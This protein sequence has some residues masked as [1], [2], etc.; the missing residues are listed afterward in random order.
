MFATNRSKTIIALTANFLLTLPFIYFLIW[1]E[2]ADTRFINNLYPLL[3]L[4]IASIIIVSE[5]IYIKHVLKPELLIL[6][7]PALYLYNLYQKMG[8]LVILYFLVNIIV[9]FIQYQRLSASHKHNKSMQLIARLILMIILIIPASVLAEIMD[10]YYFERIKGIYNITTYT[11]TE[12]LLWLVWFFILYY[13][14]EPFAFKVFETISDP[15]NKF[16]QF[17][18]I[19]LK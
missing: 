14:V 16:I 19:K 6:I 3:L 10:G 1:P 8:Y 4:K 12:F 18:N 17:L 2:M 11:E 7:I 5:L 9:D 13:I 15:K